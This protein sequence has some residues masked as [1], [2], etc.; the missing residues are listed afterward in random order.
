MRRYSTEAIV[1][2]RWPWS[3]SSLAVRLLT[4]EHGTIPA[5]FKGAY[6]LKSGY[7]GVLDTFALVQVELGGPNN[8]TMLSGYKAQL[9][10]RYSQLALQPARLSA[11]AVLAELAE[12]AAPDGVPSLEAFSLLKS[13]LTS[14]HQGADLSALLCP[15]LLQSL[16]ILGLTPRLTPEEGPNEGELWF[17]H[18]SGGVLPAQ[19]AR[20]D[21][22]ARKTSLALRRFMTQQAKA[23][24]DTILPKNETKDDRQNPKFSQ[25]T[26]T[27]LGEFLH[28]HLERPPRAWEALRR[29]QPSL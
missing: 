5:L 19:T 24:L 29:R 7:I 21:G 18:T 9:L 14:L 22:P 13:S 15:A 16:D 28:Y 3:E 12:L 2:R 25:A 20:P 23:E 10:D 1:L 6:K 17:H 4:P 11:A 26:L 8:A 27:I